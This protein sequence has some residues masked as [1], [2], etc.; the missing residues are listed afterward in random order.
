MPF[1]KFP[2]LRV[3]RANFPNLKG[4]RAPSQNCQKKSLLTHH[5]VL[6]SFPLGSLDLQQY[7]G[8]QCRMVSVVNFFDFFEIIIFCFVVDIYY[9][10]WCMMWRL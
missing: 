7:Q 2:N 5:Q 3:Y 6:P 1:K 10:I 8:V 4:P 9:V